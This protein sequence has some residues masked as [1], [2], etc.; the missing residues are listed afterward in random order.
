MIREI[1]S[2]IRLDPDG[3]YKLIIG[4]DSQ[5]KRLNGVAECDYVTAIVIHKK[6]VGARY[7]WR[8]ERVTVPPVLRERIYRETSMSL[9]TAAGIVPAIR[10]HIN[11]VG[12]YE[13]EIHIDVGEVGK[14]R[15]MIKEVVGMVTGSGYV[16]RTKPDS[17]G[18]SSVADRHT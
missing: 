7:F 13:L 12:M 3:L 8:K 11:G 4:T 16:A 9:E 10:K 5:V 18:A 1:V 15:E 17:F 6:G 14:T 2:F